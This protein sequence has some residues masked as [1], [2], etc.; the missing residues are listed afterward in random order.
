MT[1]LFNQSI[2]FCM[3]LQ[4][5]H[6]SKLSSLY[7]EALVESRHI[8]EI[9]DDSFATRIVTH[10]KKKSRSRSFKV[11]LRSDYSQVTML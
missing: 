9:L 11:N 6:E 2:I 7:L 10:L 4:R 8:V 3:A 1:I 5:E